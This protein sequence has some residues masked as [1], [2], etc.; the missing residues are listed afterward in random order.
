MLT[1][2]HFADNQLSREHFESIININQHMHYPRLFN[3]KL[4]QDF[5]KALL[6]CASQ[7]LNVYFLCVNKDPIAYEYGFL[8]NNSFKD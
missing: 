4:E 6:S 7:W 1:I 8:H 2:Q 3:S 5:L